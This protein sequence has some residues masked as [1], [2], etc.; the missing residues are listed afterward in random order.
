MKLIM[1]ILREKKCI[2]S[3]VS[4]LDFIQGRLLVRWLWHPEDWQWDREASPWVPPRTGRGLP[5]GYEG[6]SQGSRTSPYGRWRKEGEKAVSSHL[7]WFMPSDG[8]EG[9]GCLETLPSSTPQR[10]TAGRAGLRAAQE[11][12]TLKLHPSAKALQSNYCTDH[13]NHC[14]APSHPPSQ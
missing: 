2:H 6:L 12:Q 1:W 3:H 13:W 4:W 11:L 8:S 10:Q 7:T 9:N 14:T 5:L